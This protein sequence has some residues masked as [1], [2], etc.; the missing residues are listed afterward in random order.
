MR[1]DTPTNLA[2]RDAVASSTAY[3]RVERLQQQFEGLEP[4]FGTGGTTRRRR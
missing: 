1:T 4:A 3:P 2:K